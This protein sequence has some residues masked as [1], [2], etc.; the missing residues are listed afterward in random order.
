MNKA[1]S[2]GLQEV[3]A[4]LARV[5]GRTA[6]GALAGV[7]LVWTLTALVPPS[8][9]YIFQ[10]AGQVQLLSRDYPV[11]LLGL[12]AGVCAALLAQSVRRR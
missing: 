11:V 1:R 6:L 3:A 12:L 9:L 2:T 5:L 4:S 7:G 8:K 10:L